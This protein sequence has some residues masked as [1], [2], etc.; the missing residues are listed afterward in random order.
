MFVK[1]NS[2]F[3]LSGEAM[4]QSDLRQTKGIA[5]RTKREIALILAHCRL[6]VLRTNAL[7][8]LSY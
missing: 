8:A 7:N 6:V 3:F 1:E 2:S 4:A 5:M